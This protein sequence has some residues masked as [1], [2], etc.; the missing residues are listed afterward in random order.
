MAK[1][2]RRIMRSFRLDEI[3]MVDVPAQEPAKM[4][5]MKR[6]V[7]KT[8]GDKKFF[9]KDF[10]YVEDPTDPKTWKFRLTDR[11]N[12]KVT[13]VRVMSAIKQ[14]G[15]QRYAIPP[16]AIDSILD[17]LREAWMAA[18]PSQ[19]PTA[20]PPQIAEPDNASTMSAQDEGNQVPPPNGEED[21]ADA[22]SGEDGDEGDA[23]E[24]E[25]GSEGDPDF[26]PN[27]EGDDT[28]G[29][30]EANA[31]DDGSS[32]DPDEEDES[33]DKK[34]PPFARKKSNR[35]GTSKQ[36]V[37]KELVDRI[38]KAYIDPTEGAM[39]FSEVLEAAEE[40]DA[41]YEMME[42]VWPLLT[43][44]E[45]SIRSILGDKNVETSAKHSMLRSTVESFLAGIREVM[46]DV[47]EAL[48][49]V[50]DDVNG[51]ESNMTKKVEG[52]ADLATLQKQFEE[53]S[54]RVETLKAEKEEAVTKAKTLEQ[55]ASLNA[56][57]KDYYDKANDAEKA[58]FLAMNKSDRVKAIKKALEDDETVEFDG[59]VFSKRNTD[60]AVFGFIKSQV[61]HTAKLEKQ[62][63]EERTKRTEAELAKRAKDE[64]THLP[65]SEEDKIN[66]LKALDKMS[67]S[68]RKAMEAV[69]KAASSTAALAL[70]RFGT[71]GARDGSI[72]KN[73][74]G[75]H[76][77]EKAIHDIRKR[78][79]CSRTEAMQKA[80]LEHPDE[81]A[82]WNGEES[83]VH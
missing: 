81:F 10:A 60:P 16:D 75:V 13:P 67:E 2:P 76:P 41:F 79:N 34:K 9:A 17:K 28:G 33:N 80:R 42:Q 46:P 57:E 49:K 19:D 50:L 26:P 68:E 51:K 70:T 35:K 53:L 23:F 47:E 63:E 11:P 32:E 59:Q 73:N 69:L 38:L 20:M 12:G 21:P 3:S 18:F 6:R 37:K 52:A 22:A 27:G 64:L 36:N 54:K 56:D 66:I 4:T 71:N 25:E 45:T 61:A 24:G 30:S 14:F 65:G 62:L 74:G 7:T 55:I 43:A 1:Q 40:Q 31:A 5:L 83:A 77:F 58:K 82:D 78:D 29:S 44:M 8:I 72:G 39:T 15:A 48:E